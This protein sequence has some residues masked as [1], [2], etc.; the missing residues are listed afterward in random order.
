MTAFLT[1]LYRLSLL[2]KL[3]KQPKIRATLDALRARY[4]TL[5][6]TQKLLL[7]VA[8]GAVLLIVLFR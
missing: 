2:E 4:E 5:D 3:V 7:G 6:S 8:A 1:A